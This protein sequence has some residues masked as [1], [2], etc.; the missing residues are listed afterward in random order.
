MK[1]GTV[2][3]VVTE[4]ESVIEIVT[5]KILLVGKVREHLEDAENAPGVGKGTRNGHGNGTEITETDT[6][7]LVSF[8]LNYTL[9]LLHP[10]DHFS[11]LRVFLLLV[12]LLVFF[13]YRKIFLCFE[14]QDHNKRDCLKIPLISCWCWLVS[15][16]QHPLTCLLSKPNNAELLSQNTV[17]TVT[18]YLHYLQMLYLSKGHLHR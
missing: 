17:I 16:T 7:N 5:E 3:G 1:K 9:L 2:T 14:V 6:A 10:S 12:A 18:E 4:S 15:L 8:P 11:I 13:V